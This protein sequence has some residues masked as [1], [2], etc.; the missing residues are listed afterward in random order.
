LEKKPLNFPFL[1]G[2]RGFAAWAVFFFHMKLQEHDFKKPRVVPT[3]IA[4]AG[5]VVH[6]FF[7]L[8]SFLLTY[9]MLR[10]WTNLM[11]SQRMSFIKGAGFW[12][13]Y[14]VAR[15]ARIYPLVFLCA[16][17]A[18]Y[19]PTF[20]RT[21][22]KVNPIKIMTFRAFPYVFWTIELEV[23]YYLIIPFFVVLYSYA[24]RGRIF[25]LR[26]I[27]GML[28]LINSLTLF[29]KNLRP[30]LF[31][32]RIGDSYV[33]FL[34]G[35]L[36]GLIQFEIEEMHRDSTMYQTLQKLKTTRIMDA[37]PIILF[38]LVISNNSPHLKPLMNLLGISFKYEKDGVIWGLIILC[39][40]H[41]ERPFLAN[42]F[43]SDILRFYGRNS[44][45]IYLLH[46]PLIRLVLEWDLNTKIRNLLMDADA[47]DAE[48]DCVIVTI[49][50]VN[51]ASYISTRCYEEP[52]NKLLKRIDLTIIIRSAIKFGIWT[53]NLGLWVLTKFNEK[54]MA[55]TKTY[56]ECI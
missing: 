39:S 41:A 1:D 38:P 16:T 9:R 37:I 19:N 51:I 15:F 12:M 25:Y 3:F 17:V 29:I 52:L 53:I 5:P 45:A 6:S 36:A 32:S 54:F 8:S 49:V 44:F 50:L 22:Q 33:V 43:N 18:M 4:I 23:K 7:V 2:L 47:F 10:L 35:S 26:W 56:D 34:G 13:N 20:Y 42:I 24:T 30:S 55:K 21:Y 11:A 40:I 14:L 27:A 28:F 31:H 46:A 48:I